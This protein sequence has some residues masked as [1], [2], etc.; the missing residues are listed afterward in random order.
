M[1]VGPGQPSGPD[2]HQ[3]RY[4][5]GGSTVGWSVPPVNLSSPADVFGATRP[6]HSSI[7]KYLT[8]YF[9][10]RLHRAF[11]SGRR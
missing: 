8:R 6:H 7:R 11:S 5:A 9:L 2:E 4:A 3:L 10:L 1:G